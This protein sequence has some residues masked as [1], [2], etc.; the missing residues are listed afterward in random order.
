MLASQT[1]KQ[2]QLVAALNFANSNINSIIQN[3]RSINPNAVSNMELGSVKLTATDPKVNFTDTMLY[4][5]VQLDLSND[6][7]TE[8]HQAV[9][10]LLNNKDPKYQI[11]PNSQTRLADAYNSPR[12]KEITDKFSKEFAELNRSFSKG[13]KSRKK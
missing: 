8:V 2:K 9:E 3:Q 1:E 5:V 7:R 13:V 10:D 11:N 4:A 6:M 12:V